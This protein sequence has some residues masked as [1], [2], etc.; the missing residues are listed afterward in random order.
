MAAYLQRWH[1]RYKIITTFTSGRYAEVMEEAKR[2]A[3]LSFPVLP[4]MQGMRLKGGN[5]YWTKYWIQVFFE[6]LK[7]MTDEE[8]AAAMARLADAGVE[9]DDRSVR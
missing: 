2:L 6:L 4:D 9:I 5:Q 1:S 3:G 7:A 8:R